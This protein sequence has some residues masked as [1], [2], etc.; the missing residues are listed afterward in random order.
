MGA[1]MNLTDNIRLNILDSLLKKNSVIPNIRQVKRYTGYHKATIKSSLEFMQ[2]EGLLGGFGPKI[3]LRKMGYNLEVISMLQGD[4][5]KKDVMDKV[6]EVN[7]SD[8]HVYR[9]SSLIG[10]GNWNIIVRQIH[11]DIESYHQWVR[12]NYYEAIPGIFDFIRDRQIFYEIEPHYKTAS[13]T[14]S[15]IKIIKM[16]RGFE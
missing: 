10:P 11:R 9:F 6:L 2:K 3:D 13:R 16:E 14:D 12:K 8:P 4:F 15:I 1:N 7:K 5:S